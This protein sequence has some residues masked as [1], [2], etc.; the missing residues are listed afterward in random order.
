M[1]NVSFRRKTFLLLFILLL[2]APWAVSSA[3]VPGAVRP[4]AVEAAELSALEF[5]SRAWSLVR[6]TVVK[7]GCEVDPEGRCVPAPVRTKA[8]CNVDPNGRCLP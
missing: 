2:S 7:A 4:R 6:S 5:L 8:G 3:P 1:P